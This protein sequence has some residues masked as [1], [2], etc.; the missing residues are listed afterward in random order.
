MQHLGQY[1]GPQT[2]L[3]LKGQ[4]IRSKCFFYH[5]FVH[6]E[7]FLSIF[8][9]ASA[10]SKDELEESYSSCQLTCE[11]EDKE[12]ERPDPC[13]VSLTCKTPYNV[14]MLGVEILSES[15]TQEVYDYQDVYMMTSSLQSSRND[16]DNITLYRSQAWWGKPLHQCSIKV[17]LRFHFIQPHG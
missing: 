16:A 6:G 10:Q 4:V 8:S 15:R 14:S 11:P 12:G 5:G 9:E 17:G 2:L 7:S 3:I 1:W 13:V